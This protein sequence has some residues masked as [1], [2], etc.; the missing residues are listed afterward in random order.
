MIRI[1]SS[2]KISPLADIE[3]SVKGSN[4]IVGEN[5]QIDSFV[6][7]KAAGGDGDLIIGKNSYLNSGCVL[8]LGNGIKIGDDVLIAGNTVFAPTNHE[9]KD[10][11]I[12]ICKQ[13]FKMSKGGIIVEDDVWIGSNCTLLDGTHIHKGAVIGAQ[14]LIRGEILPYSINFG[15]PIKLIGFRER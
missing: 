7:I 11:N 3:N 10:G 8:Y 1:H 13:G 6:K 12:L 15:N 2:S 5:S 4:V 14:S 9:Y